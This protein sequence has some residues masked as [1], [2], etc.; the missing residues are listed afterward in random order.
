MSLQGK[1]SVQELQVLHC[2]DH[3]VAINKP[4]GLLVHRTKLDW[5]ESRFALQMLRAQLG[6]RVYPV[7]RL[8]KGTSGVLLLALTPETC[9]SLSLMFQTQQ[10]KKIYVAVVRGHPRARFG[11]IDHPLKNIK[12]EHPVS[13]ASGQQA[14]TRYKTM[15]TCELPVPVDRYPSSRYALLELRPVGGRR[16]Q[17]RRHLK[18]ISHP[19]IGDTTYGKGAHNR[20]FNDRFNVNRLLLAAVELRLPHPVT[21]ENLRIASPL[22]E[23]FQTVLDHLEW[24]QHVPE[25]WRHGGS[26]ERSI[27]IDTGTRCACN[28]AGC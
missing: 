9:R 21:G 2:D 23:D 24:T 25:P 14:V 19:I 7:H 11:V 18:H 13:E 17:L 3:I 8:D 16:H 15:A 27:K 26:P 1:H 12:D 28:L 20:M 4:S 10:I 22:A 5:H 6:R